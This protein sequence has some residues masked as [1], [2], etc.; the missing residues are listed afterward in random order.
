MSCTAWYNTGRK[1]L[2]IMKKINDGIVGRPIRLN[3]KVLVPHRNEDYAEV[4]FLGDV[5]YGSPQFDKKRFLA[6]LD[7]CDKHNVYVFLMGDLI[8]LATRHSVGAGVYEQEKVGDD[9]HSQM[10]EWLTPLAEKKLI[11]GSHQGN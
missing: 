2:C 5:H 4:I 6:M 1:V 10:V 7:Y 9:Q 8:E 11:L 3:Q